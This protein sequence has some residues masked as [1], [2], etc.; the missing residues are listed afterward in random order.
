MAESRNLRSMPDGSKSSV[1][2]GWE[3]VNS[4]IVIDGKSHHTL[5]LYEKKIK[6]TKEVL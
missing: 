5:L 2:Y 3:F 4:T 6:S 1:E